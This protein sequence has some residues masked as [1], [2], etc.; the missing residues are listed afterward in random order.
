M[1]TKDMKEATHLT[2]TGRPPWQSPLA[3]TM[4]SPL[5]VCDHL[6]AQ[7]T[8][9]TISSTVGNSHR[10]GYPSH[11][12]STRQAKYDCLA[13]PMTSR[14][15]EQT[16]HK[17]EQPN[18]NEHTHWGHLQEQISAIFILQVIINSRGQCQIYSKVLF[19]ALILLVNLLY[20]TIW[21]Y[22][23]LP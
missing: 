3:Y 2:T 8:T 13:V 20:T 18:A 1:T 12:D 7:T 9:V 16:G 19:K 5:A 14:P 11:H 23:P 21:A 10:R 17:P 15:S 22:A 4:P 6:A